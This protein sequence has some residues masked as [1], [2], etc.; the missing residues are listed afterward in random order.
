MGY[1][2][3]FGT[4]IFLFYY[5]G[6]CLLGFNYGGCGGC[7]G[8]LLF[9]LYLLGWEVFYVG[10]GSCL[11]LVRVGGFGESDVWLRIVVVYYLYVVVYLGVVEGAAISYYIKFN[12]IIECRLIL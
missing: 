1:D 4:Y 3:T 2:S 10:C 6:S 8:L 9:L 12:F 7:Y 11:R 5:H